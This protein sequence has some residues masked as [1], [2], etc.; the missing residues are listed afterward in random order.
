MAMRTSARID[1]LCIVRMGRRRSSE[2][3]GP[4]A[5]AWINEIC[6]YQPIQSSLI[7]VRPLRL[8]IRPI[9]ATH[10]GP[11]IPV[12]A[13]PFEVFQSLASGIVA[14]SGQVQIFH[15]KDDLAMVTAGNQPGQKKGAG[16]AQMEPSGGRWGEPADGL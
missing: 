15:P 3:I 2:H 16:I 7:N 12:Q 5:S 8:H 10:V 4:C 1:R 9:W 13:E 11:F 6:V 14:G